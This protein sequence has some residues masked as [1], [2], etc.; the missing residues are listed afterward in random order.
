MSWQLI[1]DVHPRLYRSPEDPDYR[2]AMPRDAVRRRIVR[3]IA[4]AIR[5]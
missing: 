1:R 4:G 3:E 5:V 2:F